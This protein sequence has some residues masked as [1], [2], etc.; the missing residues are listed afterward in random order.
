MKQW[1]LQSFTVNKSVLPQSAISSET[2]G[3][4]SQCHAPV[5]I[6]FPLACPL[7]DGG[8]FAPC[9]LFWVPGG[10]ACYP[11]YFLSCG[12]CI[13]PEHI[14]SLCLHIVVTGQGMA[15]GHERVGSICLPLKGYSYWG[16]NRSVKTCYQSSNS[17]NRYCRR[18][19][20]T[21]IS[22]FQDRVL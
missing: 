22:H 11:Y 7:E 10:G 5:S 13:M 6:H 4:A 12:R 17:H 2:A 16:W 1:S 3:I 21:S 19:S 8:G 14:W 20:G 15:Q 18:Y 9:V